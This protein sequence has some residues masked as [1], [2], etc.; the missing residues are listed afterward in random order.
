MTP[1]VIQVLLVDDDEADI[2]LTREMLEETKFFLNLDIARNGQEAIDYLKNCAAEQTPFPDLVLMD[3]NMPKKNGQEAL[4]EIKAD[5]EL[6]HIPVVILTTSDSETDI[7]KSYSN[8][9][10]CYISKPIGLDQFKSVVS[11]ISN[12]W[13]TVVKL[14]P[15]GAA[16]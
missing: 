4:N 12:F 1:T 9:A 8:G 5:A 10:N 11:I 2:V 14:P 15:K 6:R 13:F 3:L 7:L 16:K